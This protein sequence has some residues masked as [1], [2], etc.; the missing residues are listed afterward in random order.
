MRPAPPDDELRQ[1]HRCAVVAGRAID[2]RP[3]HRLAQLGERARLVSRPFARAPTRSP[4]GRVF[5]AEI[6]GFAA[7]GDD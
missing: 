3:M 4:S 7:H 2:P 6:A 5:K 1:R